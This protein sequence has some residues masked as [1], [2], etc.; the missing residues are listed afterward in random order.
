MPTSNPQEDAERL[1][2]QL[3]VDGDGNTPLPVDPIRIANSLG[4]KVFESALDES[5]SGLLIKEAGQDPNIFLNDADHVNRQRFTCAHEIGHFL[6][7]PEGEFQYVDRRD[8]FAS[9]GV[10]PEEMYANGF[11][12]ALLMPAAHVRE[13][14]EAGFRDYEM[15]LRFK[16]SVEAIKNRLNNLRLQ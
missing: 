5:V 7:R 10:S 15:A 2:G 11:A 14:H 8:H 4:I 16:V 12:A 9:A 1:L 13:L 6:R 3:W